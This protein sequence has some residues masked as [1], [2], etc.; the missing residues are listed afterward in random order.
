MG[1]D[2]AS[3]RQAVGSRLEH[4]RTRHYAPETNGVVERF[5]RSLGVRAPLSAGDR[6]RGRAGEHARKG[7]GV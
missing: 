7:I 3:C 6:Q 2:K 4:P 1:R 5:Y